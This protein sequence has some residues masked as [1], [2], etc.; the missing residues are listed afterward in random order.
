MG[1]KHWR[2]PTGVGKIFTILNEEFDFTLDVAASHANT[3]LPRYCTEDGKFQRVYPGDGGPEDYNVLK[4]AHTDGLD[5]HSWKDERVFCNPPYDG[6]LGSWVEL[7]G[8]AVRRGK[9]P[10]TVMLLP[11]SVDT[12]WYHDLFG[13][14]DKD[15]FDLVL[16]D[17]YTGFRSKTFELRF[18]RGRVKFLTPKREIAVYDHYPPKEGEMPHDFIPDESDPESAVGF[19]PRAGNLVVIHRALP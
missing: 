6:S 16:D 19:A 7:G 15:I 13:Y 12:E 10:L 14:V 18:W 3:L 11:P 8:E 4:L 17:H 9:T 2:T 5:I 1:Y